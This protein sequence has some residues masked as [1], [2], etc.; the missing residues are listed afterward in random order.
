[1]DYASIA[2]IAVYRAISMSCRLS[3]AKPEIALILILASN[4][5]VSKT[6]RK[7]KNNQPNQNDIRNYWTL[8]EKIEK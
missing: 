1:M 7:L 2:A 8:C 5:E 4:Y 6:K 3:C